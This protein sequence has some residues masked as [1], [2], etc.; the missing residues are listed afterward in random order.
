MPKTTGGS[1]LWAAPGDPE[2]LTWT[3]RTASTV[4]VLVLLGLVAC[5][6][7]RLFW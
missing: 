5:A 4:I 6:V 7:E 2:P 3:Q 1:N